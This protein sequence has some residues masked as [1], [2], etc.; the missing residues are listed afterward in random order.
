MRRGEGVCAVLFDSF[1]APPDA[2]MYFIRIARHGRGGM[3]EI[4]ISYKSERRAAAEH[5]AEV[6]RRHGFTVWFDY[7]LVKGADFAAQI[8][9]QIREAKA[10][11]ALWCSLSVSSRWVREEVHLAHDLGILVPV[12]I[13]PCEIPFGF[14][15]ADTIDLTGWDGA[16]RGAALDPLID[17]LEGRIGRDAAPDRKALIEYEGAWR[18]FGGHPL[19]DFA[20]NT[21]L[22]H[23]ETR[24][25]GP[26][27]E[28][29]PP[30]QPHAAEQA[31]APEN[32]LLQWS[33]EEWERLKESADIAQLRHFAKHA[34]PYYAAEAL[35][36]AKTKEQAVAAERRRER[37]AAKAAGGDTGGIPWK[38]AAVVGAV[39]VLALM[40]Y[41]WPHQAERGREAV[42]PLPAATVSPRPAVSPPSQPAEAT[43]PSGERAAKALSQAEIRRFARNP[44]PKQTFQECEH[45]PQM[46]VVPAGKFEMGTD[47]AGE[48][49]SEVRIPEPFAVGKYTVTFAEW[50]A[51]A[52]EDGCKSNPSPSD[53]GWGRGKQPV[54]NVSWDDAQQYI[55]WLNG[56]V[57]GKP[58]RLLSEAEWEYAARAGTQ[59]RYYWGDAI[60]SN[61]ANCDGC[62]SRWD[63]KQTAPVGSF[64]ANDFG[65]H[66]MAGN[67]WQ[68]TQD[69]WNDSY[70][71]KP[72]GGTLTTGDCS[73][74]VLRGGSW[75]Y[76][77]QDL[78]SAGRGWSPADYR[79]LIIGF[80]AA[81]TLNY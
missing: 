45:C 62:G 29:G 15:L 14:R 74:R 55:S 16:P 31:G 32:G 37:E 64:A 38:P 1:L 61:N 18:R 12:K 70:G 54:I 59:T 27:G 47:K 41:L 39:A 6:L 81:R 21:A 22:S 9:R 67:V 3:A 2:A 8:E 23:T 25:F 35:A 78:R 42:V 44:D 76:V 77:S 48:R 43:P 63:N 34:H 60:G 36:L 52:A 30:V 65:L 17:A 73:R 69:C 46:V 71:T 20:V 50:D 80:R 53:Q 72:N 56:K 5:F 49:G 28:N 19:K 40:V 79:G 51:C 75:N 66:D 4:F 10:L 33:K 24:R 7:E 58:Y 57:P 68:W 13:E 11:V 26:E